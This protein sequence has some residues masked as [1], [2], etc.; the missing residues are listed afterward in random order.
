MAPW[1]AGH[2]KPQQSLK[3]GLRNQMHPHKL[4]ITNDM[5]NQMRLHHGSNGVSLPTDLL[6]HGWGPPPSVQDLSQQGR[7]S[8]W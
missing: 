5:C 2:G 7:S 1:S 4:E 8:V 3:D 6:L